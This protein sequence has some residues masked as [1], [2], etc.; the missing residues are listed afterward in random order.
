MI[1]GSLRFTILEKAIRATNSNQTISD[2]P[3]FFLEPVFVISRAQLQQTFLHHL[4]QNF[5][6]IELNFLAHIVRSRPGADL[7]RRCTYRDAGVQAVYVDGADSAAG[8][9]DP[10]QSLGTLFIC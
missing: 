2:D 1:G 3:G 7:P 4:R 8:R 10:D 6:H 5:Q 9:V